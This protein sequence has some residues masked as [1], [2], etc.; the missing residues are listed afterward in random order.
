MRRYRSR[1]VAAL[2][3]IVGV[4]AIPVVARLDAADTGI[5]LVKL[6]YG[7]LPNETIDLLTPRTTQRRPTVVFIHGGG[8]QRATVLPDELDN[9]RSWAEKMGWVVACV[10]YPTGTRPYW[11]T[12]PSAV[13]AAVSYLRRLPQV[14]AARLAVWGESAG[15]EL[16]MSVAYQPR[17]HVRAVVSVSG[18]TDMRV[19]NGSA[20]HDLVRRFEEAAPATGYPR[21]LA[22]S[23]VAHV[24]PSAPATFQAIGLADPFVPVDQVNE[25]D[26]KLAADGV[27]HVTFELPTSDHAAT[28]DQDR[29][30]PDGPTI[31][32]AALSFL[33]SAF[34]R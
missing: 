21:Y 7:A 3:A 11:F 14:D 6:R 23:P 29:T 22:T 13:A 28:L 18:P 9:A 10:N 25:L 16:A 34:A 31:A 27:R 17:S 33:R 24:S 30:S 32:A 19:E 2:L 8:W 15:S 20:A 1:L 26:H 4:L 12:Q 5:K